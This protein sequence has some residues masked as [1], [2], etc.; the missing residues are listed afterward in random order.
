[1]MFTSNVFS[2]KCINEKSSHPA[3]D[4]K[5][6]VI[7][8]KVPHVS[9]TPNDSQAQIPGKDLGVSEN[10]ISRAQEEFY[11]LP[12]CK[13]RAGVPQPLES[14]PYP[15]LSSLEPAVGTSSA[16]FALHCNCGLKLQCQQGKQ[17]EM[18]FQLSNNLVAEQ[19]EAASGTFV[20]VMLQAQTTTVQ[21]I[22]CDKPGL[23]NRSS[24][25][26]MD[27]QPL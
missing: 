3:K 21:F 11:K 20:S 23:T 9:L 5:R 18:F 4:S 13:Q 2:R 8:L 16:Y 6:Q 12:V 19:I 15:L 7:M 22:G 24:E 14:L 26:E 1:M 27:V 10:F 17:K 25:E